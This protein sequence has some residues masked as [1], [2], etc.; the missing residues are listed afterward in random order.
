MLPNFTIG[1]EEEYQTVDPET[2]DLRSHIHA[3]IIEKGKLILKEARCYTLV[4]SRI[5]IETTGEFLCRKKHVL[6][7]SSSA[8]ACLAVLIKP[9]NN[10]FR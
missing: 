6:E 5:V 9:R 4:R 7:A 8:L 2:R 10:L 1:I 3:E